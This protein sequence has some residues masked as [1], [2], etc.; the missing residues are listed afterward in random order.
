MWNIQAMRIAQRMPSRH[1]EAISGSSQSCR[2]TLKAAR[3]GVQP[4]CNVRLC[5][6]YNNLIMHNLKHLCP[7]IGKKLFHNIVS[8]LTNLT[9]CHF[10]Q[11]KYVHSTLYYRVKYHCQLHH[12]P[13]YQGDQYN[14]CVNMWSTLNMGLTCSR[15]VALVKLDWTWLTD[16]MRAFAVT[17]M[18]SISMLYSS[19]LCFS[20]VTSTTISLFAYSQHSRNPSSCTWG[21]CLYREI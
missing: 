2:P 3:N 12:V 7:I 6:E 21:N 17:A 11:Q 19:F 13:V 18:A 1:R 5:D 10:N 16:S 15:W 20:L 4:I 9:Q 8:A 14:V